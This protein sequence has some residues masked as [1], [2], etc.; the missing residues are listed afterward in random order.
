MVYISRDDDFQAPASRFESE[1]LSL[2]VL[3][4]ILIPNGLTSL[5]TP[6]RLGEYRV[7]LERF[8]KKSRGFAMMNCCLVDELL[9]HLNGAADLK[10]LTTQ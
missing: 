8:T 6:R 1:V 2:K 10:I 9:Q 7:F 5:K 3:L 4:Q